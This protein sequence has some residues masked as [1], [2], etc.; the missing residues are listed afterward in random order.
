M[1]ITYVYTKVRSQFGR[2]PLFS[3]TN[4]QLLVNFEPDES[5]ED[6]FIEKDPVDMAVLYAP[7]MTEHE[8][9]SKT[10]TL[11]NETWSLKNR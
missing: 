7:E 6:N 9:R 5:L 4:A 10:Y 8:V 11:L 1:D 2:Q 3:D